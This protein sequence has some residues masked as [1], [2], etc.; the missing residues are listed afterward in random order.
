LPNNFNQTTIDVVH[1]FAQR[2]VPFFL[3]CHF[4][5]YC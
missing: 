1:F 2:P 3:N 4:S 5:F